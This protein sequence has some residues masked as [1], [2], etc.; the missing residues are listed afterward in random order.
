MSRGTCQT[1]FSYVE[2]LLAMLLLGVALV[3][4]TRMLSESLAGASSAGQMLSLELTLSSK[5][6]QVLANSFQILE[7]QASGSQPSNDL[8][9]PV[10]SEPRILVSVLGFDADNAD[11]DDDVLTGVDDGVLLI[12][13][14]AEHHATRFESL[15]V[16]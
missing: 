12:R 14:E 7:Q 9:D 15:R 5:L 16:R 6:E 13:V 2:V 4:I 11:G 8:S 3:P 1:G 10:G